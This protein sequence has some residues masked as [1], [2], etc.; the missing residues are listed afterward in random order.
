V[1]AGRAMARACWTDPYRARHRHSDDLIDHYCAGRSASLNA[2]HSDP[3]RLARRQRPAVGARSHARMDHVDRGQVLHRTNLRRRESTDRSHGRILRAVGRMSRRT[4]TS[5]PSRH[6]SGQVPTTRANRRSSRLD[7][8]A[9]HLVRSSLQ[10]KI[11][12]AARRAGRVAGRNGVVR[13]AR[14]DLVDLADLVDHL[15]RVKEVPPVG[16][17]ARSPARED[18]RVGSVLQ[19]DHW[20]VCASV[21]LADADLRPG[22]RHRS[23]SS[24]DLDRGP[25][26]G[27]ASVGH[28]LAP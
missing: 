21:G 14:L 7:T 10:G 11:V 18:R 3:G 28:V 15:V 26:S 13:G 17:D 6:H 9:A 12:L 27:V 22:N 2:D 23:A 25:A 1:P 24:G 16:H 4:A 19:A 5:P 20:S 8:S